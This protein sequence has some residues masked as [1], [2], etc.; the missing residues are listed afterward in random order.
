MPLHVG[1]STAASHVTTPNIVAMFG[2][3]IPLPLH[4][5]PTFTDLP[6]RVIFRAASLLTRS[7][8]G[9]KSDVLER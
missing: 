1:E 6:P 9:R 5:P 2:W 7:G 3:I 8:G 4:I